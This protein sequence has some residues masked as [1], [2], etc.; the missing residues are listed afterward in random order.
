MCGKVCVVEV[1]EIVPTGT[2]DPDLIH[3]LGSMFTGSYKVSMKNELNS[4]Q[5][6]QL[7]KG[8]KDVGSRSDGCSS[9][10]E[11]EDGMYVNLGIGIPL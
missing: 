9:S 4:A 5:R 8:L 3:L 1:E 10:K 11:L 2:L 7:L 6:A